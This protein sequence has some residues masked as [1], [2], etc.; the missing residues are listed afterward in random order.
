MADKINKLSDAI[1][2][3]ATFHPQC[4]L[5]YVRRSKSG[6]VLATCAL[7]AALEAVGLLENHRGINTVIERF[8]DVPH[9]IATQCLVA[10]DVFESS[11]EKIADWLEKQ[12]Y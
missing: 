4:R 12:G 3:G 8:P 10:S 9:T 2:L 5:R 7:A 1:R 6:K 11:R